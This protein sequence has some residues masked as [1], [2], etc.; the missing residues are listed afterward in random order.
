MINF[1]L[2]SIDL[3]SKEKF[4]GN[5]DDLRGKLYSLEEGNDLGE[6]ISEVLQLTKDERIEIYAEDTGIII[7]SGEEILS[8]VKLVEKEIGGFIPGSSFEVGKE[9]PNG[10]VRWIKTEYSWEPD[11][12]SEED[13]WGNDAYWEDK[14]DEWNEE[15]N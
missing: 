13:S 9:I 14:W 7:N 3:I 1:F 10:T 2:F 6:M 8:F 5:L 4:K 15:W 12:S 11:D